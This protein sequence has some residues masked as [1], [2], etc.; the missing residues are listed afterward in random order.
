MRGR[1]W[2]HSSHSD[3]LATGDG[4]APCPC[5]GGCSFPPWSR[6]APVSAPTPGKPKPSSQGPSTSCCWSIAEDTVRLPCELL[7]QVLTPGSGT[8]GVSCLKMD[9]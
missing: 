2:P 8:S 6:D 7:S 3:S 1:T 4:E 9:P 5:H